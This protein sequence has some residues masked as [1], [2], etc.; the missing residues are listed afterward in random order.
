[1]K[2]IY[3]NRAFLRRM[4]ASAAVVVIAF[5]FGFWELWTVT[6][7][8]KAGEA[9][10]GYGLIF[11]ALFIGGG[12]Y[13]MRQLLADYSDVVVAIDA[14]EAQSAVISVWRP[15]VSKRIVGPLD[16]L[17]NWR[18]EM[19]T[20]RNITTP[21]LLADHPNH[22]KPLQLELGKGIAISDELRALAPDAVAA[23]EKAGR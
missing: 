9:G 17:T 6:Q 21:M 12:F 19:K 18:F 4:N 2:R 5:L 14:G 8:E 3:S 20:E 22:P 7:A 1:V 23:F 16:R 10:T 13:A 15:F 11:A